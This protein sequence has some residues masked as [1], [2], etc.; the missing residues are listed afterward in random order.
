MAKPKDDTEFLYNVPR[1]HMVF[2]IASVLLLASVFLMVADDYIKEWRDYQREF[3][4]MNI[5]RSGRELEAKR[6]ELD[7]TQHM[8][9]KT[10]IAESEAE[11]NEQ[12]ER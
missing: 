5:E 7:S 9:V 4:S 6:A 11:M 1:L 8:D 12:E 10:R 2:A 3:R